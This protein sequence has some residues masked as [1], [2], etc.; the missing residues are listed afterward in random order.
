MTLGVHL[1]LIALDRIRENRSSLVPCVAFA[2]VMAL[3]VLTKGLIGLV[4]P[5]GFVLAYLAITRQLRLLARLHLWPPP[6]SFWRSPHPGT[7]SP[8]CARPQSPCLP[9]TAFPPTVAGPGSISTTSTSPA[10][11]ATASPT[12]TVRS[13]FHSSG[14]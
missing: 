10:F 8:R 1:F 9:D 13:P 5:I 6:P 2:A 4:F 14:C 12:T 11:S 3:N 7:F